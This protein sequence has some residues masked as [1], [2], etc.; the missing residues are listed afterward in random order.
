MNR[1]L[2]SNSRRR[3]VSALG[4]VVFAAGLAVPGFSSF[5]DD[6]AVVKEGLTNESRRMLPA[7]PGAEGFG[8]WSRGGRGGK[9]LGVTT[10]ED[11]SPGKEAPVPGSLRAAVMTLGPRT[12]IFQVT[13]DIRLKAP[14]KVEHP[15]ITLAGQSAPGS[16]V[17]IHGQPVAVQTHDVVIRYL[18]FRS[19]NQDCLSIVSSQ[20]V[21]VDHSS[22]EWGTDENLSLTGNNRNITLQ[23]CII[24]EGLL[25]HS[26]GSILGA[27]GGVTVHHCLYAHNAT[28][29]PRLGGIG[30]RSPIIDFH[31]NAIYDWRDNAGYNTWESVRLNYVGNYLKPGPSTPEE[32][33]G[34]AVSPGSRFTRLY[35]RDS[36][37]EGLT[38]ESADNWLMVTPGQGNWIAGHDVRE[39]C[40][41][42]EPFPTPPVETQPARQAFE[43]VLEKAGATLPVRDAADQRIVAQ[44]RAGTGRLLSSPED[45]GRPQVYTAWPTPTDTDGDGMPDA[46]ES[47]HELN[48]KECATPLADADNDGY[49]DIEEFLNGTDPRSREPWVF[50]PAVAPTDGDVFLGSTKVTMASATEGARIHYTLDGSDPQANSPLYGKPFAI[51]RT[52]TIRAR[53][54]SGGRSSRVTLATLTCATLCAPVPVT[55]AGPGLRYHYFTDSVSG[56][57]KSPDAFA[58]KSQPA[59]SGVANV[60]FEQPSEGFEGGNHRFVYEGY[61]RAPREG[62]YTFHIKADRLARLY[63]GDGEEELVFSR[64]EVGDQAGRIGL[65]K[66]LHG[67]RLNYLCP[68]KA[69]RGPLSVAWEGPGIS[70]S[71]IPASALFHGRA[72]GATP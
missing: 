71:P 54:F 61:V 72:S 3:F 1:K 27:S 53:A 33:R 14:L 55:D 9:V 66:G 47:R 4:F 51:S 31:N 62:L 32:V 46:W 45:A 69:S 30:G 25:R 41:V 28:R 23:W 67:L 22:F 35:I 36:V 18:R 26:M 49:T 59:A 15:Y 37:I 70:R 13:G 2:T 6:R 57:R 68:D 11:F 39:K 38:E 20:D 52:T 12:I 60:P 44:V 65:G 64:T 48:S 24:A 40:G 50:P 7:F 19:E 8:A 21:I 17:S 34:R 29:N 58:G 43:D 42:A 10:L 63:I 16:G 5:G 56:D